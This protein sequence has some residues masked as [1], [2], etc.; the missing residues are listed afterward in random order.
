[1]YRQA[2]RSA[3]LALLLVSP[4]VFAENP[5]GLADN[6]R[7]MSMGDSF[8]AGKG[9]IPVTQGFVYLLYHSGTFAPITNTTFA[10]AAVPTTTSKDVLNYQYPQAAK[11]RPHVVT[12]QTGGNDLGKILG[13]ANPDTVLAEFASNMHQVMCGLKTMLGPQVLV[14]V[15]NQ[16]DFPWLSVNNPAV[17]QTIVRANQMLAAEA[18]ACGAKVADNYKAFQGHESYYLYYRHGADPNEPHPTN[19]GYRAMAKAFEDAAKQ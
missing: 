2:C 12:I 11:F 6:V 5:A 15:G 3:L 18:Q 10:N 17:G 9:A 14:I 8:A 4:G 13:G 1:M 19:A 7:Y 16:P